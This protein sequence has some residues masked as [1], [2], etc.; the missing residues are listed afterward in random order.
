MSPA[1][2]FYYR[3]HYAK[4]ILAKF[5][6]WLKN[7]NKIA[8]PKS[9]LAKATQYTLNHW[10]ALTRYLS[11]GILN[12]DNNAAERG[13]K[14]VVLGRKNYLFAG[15]HQGAKAAAIFYSLIETCKL[16]G[17][18][19][20]DYFN[21]VLQRL[22]NTLNKNIRDLLPYQWKPIVATR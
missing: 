15:S 20:Y 7:A 19:T 8:L 12:I 3:R 6:R 2:R 22:P 1:E 13:I 14:P 16:F 4:P 10:R 11:D 17:V 5:Y 21:D 18:N 9:L